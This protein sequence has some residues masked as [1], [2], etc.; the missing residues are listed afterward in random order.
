MA[1]PAALRY[2]HG[3]AQWNPPTLPKSLTNIPDDDATGADAPAQDTAGKL[4]VQS[5]EIGMR[6]VAALAKHA[7]DNPAP[8]L[9]TLAASAGMP[10][11]KAH[12]Y[13]V[14][15]IRSQ[16]VE[17]D[18]NT[19]RYRLGPMARVLGVRA[20]QS[21]DVVRL[22]IPRLPEIC[23]ALGFSVALAIWTQEGPTVIA[24]E[25][26]RRPITYGTRVGE[27]MPL[28]ASATGRVFGAWL[29]GESVN[30]L[31]ERPWHSGPTSEAGAPLSRAAIERIFGEVRERGIGISQGSLT[32]TVNGLSA[33][34]FDY[35][36]AL[37]AALST[38]GPAAELDPAPDGPIA[39]KLRQLAAGLSAELGYRE[40]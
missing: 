33:P 25:D 34:I 26:P 22:V 30:P 7:F 11:A 13:M 3:P 28:L 31:L 2:L 36:G 4:G 6:L 20:I 23:D 24:V 5:I 19:S 9:K 16:L 14:S 37:V 10:P 38:L 40:P 12:R 21:L 17:R 35:R 1:I 15:L 27:V 29:P 32:P 8:M 18:E 39:R